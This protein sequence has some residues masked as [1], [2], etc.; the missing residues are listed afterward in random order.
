MIKHGGADYKTVN[1]EYERLHQRKLP[2]SKFYD[3]KKKTDSLL[4]STSKRKHF[5][6][7]RDTSDRKI[8]EEF[9]SVLKDDII[10]KKIKFTVSLVR[11]A[12]EKIQDKDRFNNVE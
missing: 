9:E 5:A 2:I 7:F 1:K 11:T 3:F 4:A 6:A 12:A 10:K 8:L